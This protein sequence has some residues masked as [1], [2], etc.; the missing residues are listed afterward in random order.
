MARHG[1]E[2]T[3]LEDVAREARL[4]RATVY[5]YF[6]GK[7]SLLAGLVA[8]EQQV[9]YQGLAEALRGTQTSED[10]LRAGLAFALRYL[11]THP[12]L[13]RTLVV[14]P[15]LVLP[16]LTVGAGPFLAAACE[17]L[18]P[19]IGPTLR[20]NSLSP[21]LVVEWL[22]RVALA[23]VLIPSPSLSLEDDGDLA[24][25]LRLVWD[26]LAWATKPPRARR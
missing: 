1:V 11:R 17:A 12:V 19:L 5:S 23:Y 24:V 6:A 26:G 3:S 16:M 22:A 20:R 15:E 9:L 25:A 14:E 13:Q 2:R 10:G 18:V 21:E 8:H 7:D 4:S